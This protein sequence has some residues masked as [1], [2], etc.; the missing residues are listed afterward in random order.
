MP[1]SEPDERLRQIDDLPPFPVELVAG[2]EPD[3]GGALVVAGAARVDALA[4]VAEPFGERALDREV[5]VLVLL[6]D[7]KL[8]SARDVADLRELAQDGGALLL[9]EE[10]RRDLHAREH[11]DVRGG[12]VAVPLGEAQVEN[13]V[14]ADGEGEHVGV[15]GADDGFGVLRGSGGFHGAQG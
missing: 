5:T 4:E 11:R 14:L 10:L 7:P 8:A 2:E 13:G 15:D 12:A 9:R 6:G 3:R 1:L